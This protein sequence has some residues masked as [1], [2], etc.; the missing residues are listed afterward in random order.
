MRVNSFGVL[1]AL[2]PAALL[3]GSVIPAAL[4]AA[5]T[6]PPP[7]ARRMKVYRGDTTR[8]S[9]TVLRVTM[10]T[11]RIEQ[12]VHDL[13]AS[14]AMEQTIGQSLREAAGQA[15]DPKKMRE[16]SEELGRI[17]Q[18]NASLIT[19]IE[20]SCAGDRQP[21]GYIGVQFSELQTVMGDD[22]PPAPPLREYPRIDMVYPGSPA[23]KAG[24]RR[25]DVVLL[26]G[27]QDSRRAVSL[28]KLL[29]PATKLPIRVQRDGATKDLT[30]VVE[31]RPPDFNSECS[32]LDQFI[33]PEF[34]QPMI[35]MRSPSGPRAPGAPSIVLRNPAPAVMPDAPMPPM[36]P[37][38]P[39]VAGYMYGFA[40][41]TNSAIAGATLMPL[42]DDWRATLGVDNGVLVTKV[43]PGTPAKDSGL[44]DG[45]VITAADGQ[46][47]AS[48]RA[49]TRIVG[50]SKSNS[51]KLQ[52]IRAGKQQVVVLKWQQE[53]P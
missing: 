20:M 29:K 7:A 41:T 9:A 37:A 3:G 52:V 1:R 27:G 36:P 42:T 10:N 47:V 40:T 12:L 4:F 25:G 2:L 30:I 48:V 5:Q 31:K 22:A 6:D 49:L 16:L 28:D 44:R 11:D 19:T 15:A 17:A 46:S 50:N 32:N 34:D 14:R 33:S 23:S 26:M 8:D 21:D 13:M 43:L 51:V 38:M 45:D 35:V 24:L 53:S 18:K 39:P